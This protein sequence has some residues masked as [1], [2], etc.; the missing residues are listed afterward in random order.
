MSILGSVELPLCPIWC[1]SG[2]VAAASD[3]RGTPPL[4]LLPAVCAALRDSSILSQRAC[5][6]RSCTPQ[7][8]QH[9][10]L[11]TGTRAESLSCP[12]FVPTPVS[13]PRRT[14]PADVADVVLH[15]CRCCSCEWLGKYGGPVTLPCGEAE[16]VGSVVGVATV[17][18]EHAAS[19]CV[20]LLSL[21]AF[22]FFS[23]LQ[24]PPSYPLS[25]PL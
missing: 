15:Y 4:F 21:I 19:A 10:I 2:P 6:C 13:V 20:V 16:G 22:S 1:V 14:T 24:Q 11:I 12:Q 3:A 25:H 7:L 18:C 8:H 9:T 23:S 5:C 17:V